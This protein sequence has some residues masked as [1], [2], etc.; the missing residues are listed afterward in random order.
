MIFVNAVASVVHNCITEF[1]G[2]PN[3]NVGNS[4]LVV[5]R[6]SDHPQHKQERLANCS[7]ISFMK[8]VAQ[9][10][11]S[12]ALAE[13]RSH[14]KII[15]RIPGYRVRMGFGLHTGWAIEGAIGSEFK[16]DASYL[17]PNVDMTKA[18]QTLTKQYGATILI[19]EVLTS[20][21][22]HDVATLCRKID[23]VKL[24]DE[25]PFG[26]YT[27]DLDDMA[28]EVEQEYNSSSPTRKSPAKE[29][30]R[31]NRQRQRQLKERWDDN[32]HMAGIIDIDPDMRTMRKKY[33]SEFFQ[34]FDEALRFY[35]AGEWGEAA[36]ILEETRFMNMV[37]DG[38]S[39]ALLRYMKA[40]F[41]HPPPEW[42]GYRPLEVI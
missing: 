9:I 42:R 36:L 18:L 13:Y 3:Q 41:N 12:A 15:K 39:S 23:R 27:M 30:L 34:R 20:L 26:L 40:H 16:I 11:T 7:V 22:S 5:W 35:E 6:L 1:F 33:S 37:E 25:N 32:Y 19:S 4:F 17:S 2:N 10:N 38:P 21:M 14:P 24:R 29:K 8:I 28:L 31:Q